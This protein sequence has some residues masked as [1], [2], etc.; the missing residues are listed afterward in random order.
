MKKLRILGQGEYDPLRPAEKLRVPADA[1]AA[2]WLV[3]TLRWEHRA[4][5]LVTDRFAAYGRVFHP[6]SQRREWVS[7][8]QDE[9]RW[10]A[11]A[12]ANGRVMHGAAEWG[13]IIGSWKTTAQA[14]LWDCAPTRGELPE[15][16]ALLVAAT[17]RAHTSSTEDCYFGVWEGTGWQG[18]PSCWRNWVGQIPPRFQLPSREMLLLAGPLDAI[19]DFYAPQPGLTRPTPPHIWWPADHAWCVATDVD[20]LTSYVGAREHA[21][22]AL[23]G[24]GR[25]E[26]LAIPGDQPISWDADKINPLPAPPE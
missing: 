1:Q 16:I 10:A 15:R 26:A 9:V 7:E 22:A 17:L 14:A 6:A 18:D 21:I 20:L 19:E 13:S 8:P 24:D 23:V 5:S 25:I 12:A 4:D 11:V 3:E 2:D